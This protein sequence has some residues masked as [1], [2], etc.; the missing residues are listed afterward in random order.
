MKWYDW[1]ASISMT[2]GLAVLLGMC[3]WSVVLHNKEVPAMVYTSIPGGMPLP[4][5]VPDYILPL[6]YATWVMRECETYDVPIWLV[7]RLI[8][9]ESRWDKDFKS[10]PYKSG[11][12]GEGLGSHNSRFT[13]ELGR[14]Y[15]LHGEAYDPMDPRQNIEVTVRLLAHLWEVIILDY[16]EWDNV[17]AAYNL[18]LTGWRKTPTN[19]WPRETRALVEYVMGAGR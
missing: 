15:S 16:C 1:V 18:G 10:G 4:R 8:N 6:Q 13:K 17:V 3:V 11:G 9:Y 12:R 7:C 19:K 2:I 14:L 5:T